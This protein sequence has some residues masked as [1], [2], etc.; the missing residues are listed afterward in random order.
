MGQVPEASEGTRRWPVI[1]MSRV[2]E[3]I[4]LRG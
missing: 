1:P 3:H 4:Q 2:S